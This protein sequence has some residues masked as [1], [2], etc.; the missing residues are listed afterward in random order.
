MPQ[1]EAL[2]LALEEVWDLNE[3]IAELEAR[4]EKLRAAILRTCRARGIDRWTHARG[5][6]RIQRY[7]AYKIE[8]PSRVLEIVTARGWTDE[9]LSVRGRSLY[10]LALKDDAARRDLALAGHA[11][12]HESL[13]LT[14]K[15]R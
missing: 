8:K 2:A 11:V 13:V 9:A 1:D 12:E 15:K 4:R 3:A 5:A 14:A 6:L 10:K 7:M